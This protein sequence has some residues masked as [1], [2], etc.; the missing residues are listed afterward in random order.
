MNPQSILF[1]LQNIR[2]LVNAL[3]VEVLTALK[4][5]QPERTPEQLILSDLLERTAD[6]FRIAPAAI[7]SENRTM[8]LVSA[9]TALVKAARQRGLGW[10]TIAE[11]LNKDH[12]SIIYLE[13]QYDE[14]I[15][16]IPEHAQAMQAIAVLQIPTTA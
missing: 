13:G 4:A 11:F 15:L 1:Q 5:K 2:Q 10:T 12:S 9:R 14:R 16:R 3:E 8:L 7:L 6:T